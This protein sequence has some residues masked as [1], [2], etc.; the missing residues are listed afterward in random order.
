MKLKTYMKLFP[1][2]KVLISILSAIVVSILAIYLF[3]FFVVDTSAENIVL[4]GQKLEDSFVKQKKSENNK[5]D[6]K[7]IYVYLAGEVKNPGVVKVKNKSR[8]FECLEKAGGATDQANMEEHNLAKVVKDGEKYVFA[9]KNVIAK[10]DGQNTSSGKQ[11]SNKISLSNAS[12]EDLKSLNGIGDKIAER[13]IKY[14]SKNGS[15]QNIEQL[16]QVKGIGRSLFDK[17]KDEIVP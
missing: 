8:L 13:I 11:P 6:E 15:F 3:N 16:R 2:K 5:N 4:Q 12:K 10:A 9:N 1:D 7:E 14:R 17:I